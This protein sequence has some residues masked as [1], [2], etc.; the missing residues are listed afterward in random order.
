MKDQAPRLVFFFVMLYPSYPQ[1]VLVLDN[2][3]RLNQK[4]PISNDWPYF[5]YRQIS[6]DL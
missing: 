6:L 2:K 1:I 5:L 3:G 4:R